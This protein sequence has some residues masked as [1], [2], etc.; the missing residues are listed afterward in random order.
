METHEGK[1]FSV[2]PIKIRHVIIFSDPSFKL[3]GRKSTI[4]TLNER[5]NETY[6]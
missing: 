5:E 1:Y 4:S 2:Y 6:C 3:I